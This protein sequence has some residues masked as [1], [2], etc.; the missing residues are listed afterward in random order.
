MPPA[1]LVLALDVPPAFG[2]AAGLWQLN[3]DS[4]MPARRVKST[5]VTE[6]VRNLRSPTTGATVVADRS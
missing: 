6:I 2:F 5:D 4:I 3:V 1:V